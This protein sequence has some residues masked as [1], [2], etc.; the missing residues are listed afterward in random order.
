MILDF[1]TLVHASVSVEYLAVWIKLLSLTMIEK[2]Y[3]V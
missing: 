2:R 1:I 3:E